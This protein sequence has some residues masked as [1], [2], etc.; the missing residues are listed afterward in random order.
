MMHSIQPFLRA[1]SLFLCMALWAIPQAHALDG[2]LMTGKTLTLLCT[3]SKDDDQ[4]SCQSYIAGII[5]YHNLVKSLGT[6]PSVNFCIPKEVTMG[7]L[8]QIVTTYI[9]AH[10]EHQDFIAAPGVAMGLYNAYPCKKR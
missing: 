5:D 1:I 10:T 2:A 4:F 6:A 7:Q 9:I 8:K 3:S